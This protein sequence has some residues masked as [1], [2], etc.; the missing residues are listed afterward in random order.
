MTL[1][2]VDVQPGFIFMRSPSFDRM[3]D[4]LQKEII[5][6]KKKNAGI[7]L[8]EY[9]K[10]G[11]T[12]PEL[13]GLLDNYDQYSI[14]R[15]DSDNGGIEVIDEIFEKHYDNKEIK[16]GGIYADLCVK[17]TVQTLHQYLPKTS[18]ITV[19]KNGCRNFYGSANYKFEWA[20]KLPRVRVV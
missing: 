13:R 10:H 14:I 5:L 19:L 9:E 7:I 17:A 18:K 11:S 12:I 15:K 2:I 6:A 20:K 3:I 1:I 4:K 8:L 16:V